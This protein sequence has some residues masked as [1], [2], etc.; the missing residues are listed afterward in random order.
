MGSAVGAGIQRGRSEGVCRCEANNCRLTS[1]GKKNVIYIFE[2][3]GKR[4]EINIE[5]GR[6]E[7]FSSETLPN[8][9]GRLGVT[10][11]PPPKKNLVTF[12]HKN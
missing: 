9:G 6:C 7:H 10:I 11:N 3:E 5:G 1:G 4:Q 12:G 8:D 2:V